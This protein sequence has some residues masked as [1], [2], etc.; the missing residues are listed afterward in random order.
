MALIGGLADMMFRSSVRQVTRAKPAPLVGTVL[1]I[2]SYRT[3]G[4]IGAGSNVLTVANN[5]G[6]TV[7]DPIIVEIGAEAGAGQRAT[8]GVGGTWPT[9]H[10]ASAAAMNAD[11]TKPSGTFAYLDTTQEV[12][13]WNGSA[14]VTVQSLFEANYYA[15]KFYPKALVTTISSISGTQLTLAAPAVAAATGANVY[16]NNEPL[17]N[18]LLYDL[19][20]AFTPANNTVIIPEGN[21][22]FEGILRLAEHERDGWTVAGAG[23]DRTRLFAPK[24]AES[25]FWSLFNIRAVTLHDFTYEGNAGDH[26]FGLDVTD[27]SWEHGRLWP[28]GIIFI[29]DG[30]KV[31]NVK[32]KNTFGHAVWA[33]FMSNFEVHDCQAELTDGL[34]EYLASWQFGQSNS[35]GGTFSDCFV[36]SPTLTPGLECFQSGGTRFRRIH[37]HNA[38]AASNSSFHSRWDECT[39]RMDTLIIPTD[40]PNGAS[41]FGRLL[42]I[43]SNIDPLAISMGDLIL[44]CSMHQ[45]GPVD[46]GGA[47]LSSII[48]GIN[49]ANVVIRGTYPSYNNPLGLIV[50]PDVVEDDPLVGHVSSTGVNTLVDGIRMR[51]GSTSFNG[52]VVSFVAEP[53]TNITV[54]NCVVDNINTNSVPVGQQINNITNAAYDAGAP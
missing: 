39:W 29:A 40:K 45:A 49:S 16:F 46:E 17:W 8:V 9:L 53:R 43:N 6:F 52:P 26:G 25:I 2:K 24:G 27:T 19:P 44:N 15:R 14:W 11:T 28:P 22:A 21:Y 48:V 3:T 47:N 36:T 18:D 42:D 35:S 34:R 32:V 20:L 5:P 38:I 30:S 51:G 12:W 1:P 50:N 23:I 54:Q 33:E 10:Y 41:H 37:L 4:N 7:G 31:Y 13:R